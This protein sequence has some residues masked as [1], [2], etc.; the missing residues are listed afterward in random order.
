VAKVSVIIPLYNKGRYIARTLDSVFAQT[1]QDFEVIVVDDG[2]SDNGGEVVCGYGDP[3][4]RMIRQENA[5]PGAARNRGV[6]ESS[7]QYVAFLDA[8]DEWMPDF[9]SRSIV[10]LSNHPECVLA[11]S[12]YFLGKDKCDITP[13]LRER[14]ISD[15]LWQIRKDISQVELRNAISIFITGSVLC[16]RG[17]FERYGGFY[18][19]N[20][21]SYG[22]DYY[23]WL[24][25]MFN[26]TIYRILEP[27]VWYH[28]EVSELGP[29]RT[30][31]H[32]IEPFLTDPDP[33][34]RNCP[35]EYRKLLEQWLAHY[36]LQL[37]HES[38]FLGHLSKA[39][40][41]IKNYP[42]MKTCKWE[43]IK[44]R[45]KMVFPRLIPIVKA[46][47]KSSRR[48]QL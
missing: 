37:A 30:T 33:I 19:K 35:P 46:L 39:P 17:I 2:S 24:Q 21:C 20:G 36:A 48:S 34:R 1:Y 14:G 42:L 45:I 47:K 4:L 31:V 27:L 11:A 9:L 38:V 41:L 28:S 16:E 32:P 3:R 29:G 25:V 22:E 10:D 8:D 18:G 40:F 6:K 12:S 44:L 23:L 13:I 5:G 43:Y 7:A 26:H 15:G